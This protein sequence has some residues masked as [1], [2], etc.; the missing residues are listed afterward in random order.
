MKTE[1][2]IKLAKQKYEAD[3]AVIK[4]RLEAITVWLD[5]ASFMQNQ[6][7][8]IA[9]VKERDELRKREAEMDFKVRMVKWVLDEK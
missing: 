2:T 5:A 3:L 4:E 8:F 6:E 7:L 1:A 9:Q